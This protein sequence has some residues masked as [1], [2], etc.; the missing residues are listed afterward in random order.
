MFNERE[1]K[2]YTFVR[3]GDTGEV[4]EGPESDHGTG[5]A[6]RRTCTPH[7]AQARKLP[8]NMLS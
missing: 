3:S 2:E 1:R 8:D 6:F 4:I 5:A 7:P